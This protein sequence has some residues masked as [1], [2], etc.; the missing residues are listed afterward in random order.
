[1]NHSKPYD[2]R[3]VFKLYVKQWTTDYCKL[4]KL[5]SISI[6]EFSVLGIIT[7]TF[8][9]IHVLYRIHTQNGLGITTS[10]PPP[11]EFQVI[12]VVSVT[13]AINN[14]LAYITYFYFRVSWG[15]ELPLYDQFPCSKSFN[16]LFQYL[17]LLNYL[18]IYP[19]IIYICI[20]IC[21]FKG[22]YEN[23]WQV[24]F[25]NINPAFIIHYWSTAHVTEEASC[26]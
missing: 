13:V 18:Y 11:L 15:E 3:S 1:M 14:A 5:L 21:F 19:C 8:Q 23:Q 20:F 16:H 24:H 4:P 7:P 25:I 6:R 26:G 2:V 17:Y 12:N 10:A 22:K 9:P